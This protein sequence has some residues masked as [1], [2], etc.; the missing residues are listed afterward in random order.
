MFFFSLMIPTT[1]SILFV[2]A[3]TFNLILCKILDIDECSDE[4][5]GCSSYALCTNFVGGYNCTCLEGYEGDGI[6]CS[7]SQPMNNRNV[8]NTCIHGLGHFELLSRLH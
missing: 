5:G 2:M 1:V 3:I 7:K 8:A 4:N 6:N